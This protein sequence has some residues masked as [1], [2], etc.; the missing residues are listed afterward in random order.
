ML[1]VGGDRG[2]GDGVVVGS[3]GFA[4]GREKGRG[5]ME[6]DEVEGNWGNNSLLYIVG[7]L[8]FFVFQK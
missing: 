4:L 3:G 5:L 8:Q 6:R 2:G 1:V 7:S